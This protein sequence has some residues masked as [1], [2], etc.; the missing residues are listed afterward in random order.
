HVRSSTPIPSAISLGLPQ[1][2]STRN[3][4]VLYMASLDS[5]AWNALYPRANSESVTF[6]DSGTFRAPRSIAG[7]LLDLVAVVAVVV[8]VAV[9]CLAAH[10]VLG[11]LIPAPEPWIIG[12][13]ALWFLSPVFGPFDA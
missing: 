6:G 9:E 7:C 11:L 2:C 8:P 13:G 10:E 3:V 5:F 1:K 12:L 4:A